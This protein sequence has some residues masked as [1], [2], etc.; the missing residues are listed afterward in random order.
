LPNFSPIFSSVFDREKT[1]GV[2][3]DVMPT[4]APASTRFRDL[5][6]GL[7]YADFLADDLRRAGTLNDRLDDLVL[8]G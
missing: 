6:I 1:E 3:S 8:A 4:N 5:A 7:A 2:F